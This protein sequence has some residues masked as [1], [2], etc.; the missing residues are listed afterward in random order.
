M[1][2]FAL[3]TGTSSMFRG[4]GK[5]RNSR[6]LVLSTVSA[7][8]LFALSAAAPATAQAPAPAAPGGDPC[9]APA[10]QRDPSA[11]CPPPETS[12]T[13]AAAQGAAATNESQ[14]I[15]VVGSRIPR[16]NFDTVQPSTVLTSQ[17]IEQ[18][19]FVNA[20]D[21]L[22]ELPQFGIPGSSPVGSAQGGAFGSGQSFVDFLGLG[23]QRTL[24]LVNGRRFVSSNSASIFGPT[25]AGEQVDLGLINTK[26]IDR[27]ETIAIGGAP[28]YGSGGIARTINVIFKHD[29]Q[30][31][32]LDGQN[33]WG[34]DGGF[35]GNFPRLGRGDAA[36]LWRRAPPG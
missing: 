14:N 17:A 20:A 31:V 29:Y 8:A 35:F 27:I 18:R 19:G 11:N 22:N 10:D 1:V 16:P 2:C 24:V 25:A 33:G 9:Q 36:K 3:E 23:S 32:D 28:I 5:M 26:L 4:T 6:F 30:G 34:E 13:N 15:I 7:A 21:A 12:S